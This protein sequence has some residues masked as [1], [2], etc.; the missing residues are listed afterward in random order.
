[1]LPIVLA[2]AT[3]SVVLFRELPD[4][5]RWL[6]TTALISDPTLGR[7]V[8][9]L[10]VQ[11]QIE[12][13]VIGSGASPSEIWPVY[14]KIVASSS[15]AQRIALLQHQSAVVRGYFASYVI[16]SEPDLVDMVFPLFADRTAVTSISGCI[17]E[18]K[19]M[20]E[21]VMTAMTTRAESPR[22]LAMAER[23]VRDKRLVDGARAG[24]LAILAEAKASNTR[25]LALAAHAEPA[26]RKVALDAL[27]RVGNASD[28]ELIAA[29]LP[30]A[31]ADE[32]VSAVWALGAIESP[33]ACELVEPYLADPDV[34]VRQAAHRAYGANRYARPER[35]RAL[36]AVSASAAAGVASRGTEEA[37]QI[38]EPLLMEDGAV[39]S[40]AVQSLLSK[41]GPSAV[42]RVRV[43]V[44]SADDRVREEARETLARLGDVRAGAASA[45]GA[46]RQGGPIRTI[47][48]PR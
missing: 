6:P 29:S 42:P 10:A 23:I 19:S 39:D 25:E 3:H 11:P 21:Y 18:S 47:S 9:E 27:G 13:R 20:A 41:M 31:D 17:K 22:V 40:A 34:F 33:R 12:G 5:P 15:V 28:V 32:R 26:L 36:L 46:S 30:R 44:Q 2:A 37:L 43:L 4:A 16:A 35:L 38:L 7:L 8:D 14:R 45:A 48:D 1:M 24:A